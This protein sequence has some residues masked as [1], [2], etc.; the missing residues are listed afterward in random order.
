MRFY[1]EKAALIW[2]AAW[3]EMVDDWQAPQDRFLPERTEEEAV[4]RLKR[5]KKVRGHRAAVTQR[6]SRWAQVFYGLR[7]GSKTAF[8]LF[9]VNL[10]WSFS[11]STFRKHLI[12]KQNVSQKQLLWNNSRFPPILNIPA[13][14]FDPVFRSEENPCPGLKDTPVHTSP[15]VC[16]LDLMLVCFI[17]GQCSDSPVWHG[18][19]CILTWF[20]SLCLWGVRRDLWSPVAPR[21]P[22]GPELS[23]QREPLSRQNQN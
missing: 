11:L 22:C 12:L 23:A 14:T 16:S 4:R 5:D 3:S 6:R 1:F 20:C 15:G 18:Q 19:R 21:W 10:W 8:S 2:L 13:V 7:W 9:H 17:C